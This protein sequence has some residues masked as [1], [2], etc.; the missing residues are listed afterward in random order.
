MPHVA[1]VYAGS[2][3]KLARK[4]RQVSQTELASHVG[5]SFQQVQKYE[6]GVNRMGASRLL[7]FSQFLEVPISFFFDP[8][9][10][11]LSDSS[12]SMDENS[13]RLLAN[14]RAIGDKAA[15]QLVFDMVTWMAKQ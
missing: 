1:D 9:Q 12:F 15:R 7:Q 6:K 2:R 3:L 4:L 14:Y 8:R 11:M 13:L 10:L 5:L